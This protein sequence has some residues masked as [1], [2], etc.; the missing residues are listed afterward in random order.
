MNVQALRPARH[1]GDAIDWKK[2]ALLRI[3][4]APDV[5]MND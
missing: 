2:A 5:L 4:C 3:P 1:G